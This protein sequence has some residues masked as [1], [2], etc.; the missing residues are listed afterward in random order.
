LVEQIYYILSAI[1]DL[2]AEMAAPISPALLDAMAMFAECADYLNLV[3]CLTLGFR[4]LQKIESVIRTQQ[5]MSMLKR[6]LRQQESV[7]QLED[8]KISLKRLLE[9][10]SVGHTQRKITSDG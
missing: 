6:F 9:F 7:A 5:D 4:T 1:V 3:F 2:Y 8:C 10:F